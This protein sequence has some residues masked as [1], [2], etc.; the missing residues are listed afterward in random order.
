MING[1]YTCCMDRDGE[2]I[3]KFKLLAISLAYLIS[4]YL[5]ASPSFIGIFT[6]GIPLAVVGVLGMLATTGVYGAYMY[7]TAIGTNTMPELPMKTETEYSKFKQLAGWFNTFH[8]LHVNNNLYRL[9]GDLSMAYKEGL[10]NDNP[11][12]NSPLGE[13]L[14]N[15]VSGVSV[16]YDQTLKILSEAFDPNDITYQNYL[17]VLDD[18]LKL[19]SA[20]LKS[21]KKRLCVFDYRTWS[22]DKNDEMCRRYIGE[23][24][25]SV[26]RLEE[27]CDK[28]DTLIHELICLN[29]ISEAP[30]Q[31]MQNLIETTSDY[32]SIE[33]Q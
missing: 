20:H 7:T 33:D 18:V 19:S 3:V 31:D 21:V 10:L 14:H 11:F 1:R 16:K 8:D 25:S 2:T 6:H 15:T 23:V 26:K 28:F 9:N 27:I 29:E 17:S 24:E 4:V 30:L 22:E 13:R 12:R 32:K 5:L